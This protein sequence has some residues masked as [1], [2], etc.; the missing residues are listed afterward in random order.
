MNTDENLSR[1]DQA[2]EELLRIAGREKPIRAILV[3]NVVDSDMTVEDEQ[4]RWILLTKG[5]W[6]IVSK[7]LEID[8]AMTN[9]LGGI[10]VYF[11]DG[12]ALR[13]L[14]GAEIY[15]GTT[16]FDMLLGMFVGEKAQE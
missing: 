13:V 12:M 11:D 8:T 5:S 2:Q 14:A 1:I 7:M 6:S 4:H 3:S 10:P 9:P 16:G 15:E